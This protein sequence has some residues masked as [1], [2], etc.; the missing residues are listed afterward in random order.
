[1]NYRIFSPIFVGVCF[2]GL[3]A[4]ARCAE[5]V[6]TAEKRAV[7]VIEVRSADAPPAPPAPTPPAPGADTPPPAPPAPGGWTSW[8]MGEE[9]TGPVTFL[10]VQTSKVEAAL[11][12]Q[13]GLPRGIGLVVNVV[14]GGGPVEGVL[15]KHDVLVKFD[16][17]L[18]TSG[19]HLGVL[20]RAKSPGDAAVLTYRRAGQEATATVTLGQRE[21]RTAQMPD[22]MPALGQRL[23][24]MREGLSKVLP[25]EEIERVMEALR[26]A[27][28]AHRTV[29]EKHRE[30]QI[31]HEAAQ[32]GHEEAQRAHEAAH[33]AA[34]EAR[35]RARE[36]PVARIM[37]LGN[38]HIRFQD[39][40]GEIELRVV[41]GRR[42]AKITD[43]TGVVLYDGPLGT[44]EEQVALPEAVKGRLKQLE[45][46]QGVQL[47]PDGE[48]P[49]GEVHFVPRAEKIGRVGPVV[50][51]APLAP[52]V[53]LLEL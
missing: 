1:M 44:A 16:D 25:R 39:D 50:P 35:L 4:D 7:R 27:D 8:M 2:V 13:L 18:L 14:V 11:G 41:E 51:V 23:E 15:E 29:L 53:D 38:V 48:L 46:L 30:V 34:A 24:S 17:Q 10:G 12:A 3:A 36:Q 9:A 49:D 45:N 42:V 5:P 20:V 47:T 40:A 26:R 43:A 28:G 6:P 31:E 21:P 33:E 19:E 32:R 52:R 37:N 22:W